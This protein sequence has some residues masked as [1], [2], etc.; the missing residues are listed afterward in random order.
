MVR[1]AEMALL[2]D[3]YRPRHQAGAFLILPIFIFRAH[4]DSDT[5]LSHGQATV[6]LVNFWVPYMLICGT[7]NDQHYCQSDKLKCMALQLNASSNSNVEKSSVWH[8][9]LAGV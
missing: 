4:E 7:G 1:M 6:V 8:A 2:Q 5:R 9:K 3:I